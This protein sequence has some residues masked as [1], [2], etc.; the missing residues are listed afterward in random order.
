MRRSAGEGRG[1]R[2]EGRGS[3]GIEERRGRERGR[4]GNGEAYDRARNIMMRHPPPL[5]PPQ[6]LLNPLPHKILVSKVRRPNRGHHLLPPSPSRFFIFLLAFVALTLVATGRGKGVGGL[7]GDVCSPVGGEGEVADVDDAVRTGSLVDVV[8]LLP[9]YPKR[10]SVSFPRGREGG[11]A[12]RE[13]AYVI[14]NPVG[15]LIQ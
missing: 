15:I 14:P 13:G 5:P 8:D 3:V 12:R 4:E 10:G 1:V 6:R 2:G 11:E 7:G 9:V